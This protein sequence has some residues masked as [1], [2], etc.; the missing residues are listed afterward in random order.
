MVGLLV[1]VSVAPVASLDWDGRSVVHSQQLGTSLNPVGLSL[2]SRLSLSVPLYRNLEGNLW[3]PAKVEIGVINRITP[4]FDDFGGELYFEP[5]AVADVRARFV[6][7]QMFDA[8]GNGYAPLEGPDVNYGPAADLERDTRAGT[9]V[10]ISPRFKIAAGPVVAFNQATFRRVEMTE[11]SGES[12]WF[13]EPLGDVA[14]E[15]GDWQL[16]NSAVVLWDTPLAQGP[17]QI[18]FGLD[19]SLMSVDF[20]NP[21]WQRV[22]L[23]GVWSAPDLFSENGPAFSLVGIVGAQLEH[24]YYD[25]ADGEPYLA[26]Q[27][28]VTWNY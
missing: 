8:L 19:Y 26:V 25:L 14:Q 17:R 15:N 23:M 27:A 16:G 3:D 21:E 22:S 13:Y 9:M 11:K 24:R 2:S 28:G 1:V 20:D 12:G 5:I 7:R 18:L 4:A 10:E 6:V